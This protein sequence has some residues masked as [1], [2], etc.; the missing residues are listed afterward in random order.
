MMKEKYAKLLLGE[1]MSGGGKGVCS[2]LAISNAITNLS[3][4]HFSTMFYSHFYP[5]TDSSE[6]FYSAASVFGEIW[7]LEPLSPKRKAMWRREMDWLVSVADHI[8]ELVPSLQTFP[9][10]SNFEVRSSCF[11]PLKLELESNV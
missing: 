9:D 10:G 6:L 3:G 2:A 7:R 11:L 8:V 1:D 5:S 4:Q